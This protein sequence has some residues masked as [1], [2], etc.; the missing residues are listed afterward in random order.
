MLI[1]LTKLLI[2]KQDIIIYWLVLNFTRIRRDKYLKG[3][4]VDVCCVL[5]F[6]FFIFTHTHTQAS[7]LC[8][9]QTAWNE[10]FF[11]IHW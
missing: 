3:V 7:K 5:G 8:G 11:S 10:G 2:N 9:T 6:F 4:S 1:T